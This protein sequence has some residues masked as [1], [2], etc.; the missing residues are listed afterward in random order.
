MEDFEWLRHAF[1]TTVYNS[2]AIWPANFED[3]DSVIAVDDS[4]DPLDR[5][6][7]FAFGVY[8]IRF[9]RGCEWAALRVANWPAERGGK[10]QRRRRW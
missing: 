9:A 6:Q 8:R 2:T 7:V 5:S 10:V 1:V 4:T 3:A